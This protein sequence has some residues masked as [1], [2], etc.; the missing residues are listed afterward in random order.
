MPGDTILPV[1]ARVN[2]SNGVM[3]GGKIIIDYGEG[4]YQSGTFEL[5]APRQIEPPTPPAP[6]APFTSRI[7]EMPT[8]S[9]PDHPD[10][11]SRRWTGWPT[12]DDIRGITIHHTMSHSPLA[13]ARYCTNS[14]TAGGKGYPTTQYHYWVSADDGC[15]VWQLVPDDVR[16]WHDHTGAMQ[17]NLS[18]G[19]AGSLHVTPPPQEQIEA[20]A[21]LI[22]WLADKY[23]L[24]P[25]DIAGHCDR[26]GGTVCPGWNA[27]GWKVKFWEALGR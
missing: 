20:A 15:P 17:Y 24:E 4:Y 8:N 22:L 23:D 5:S 13:T 16:L 6:V 12:S 18:V 10:F 27:A 1:A 9:K 25:S 3:T 11:V 21:K 26:Y 2:V 19:L 7:D 14:V